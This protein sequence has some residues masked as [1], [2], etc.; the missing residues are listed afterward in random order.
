MQPNMG[1]GVV[2]RSLHIDEAAQSAM[3]R[4]FIAVTQEPANLMVLGDFNS[5]INSNSS[6]SSQHYTAAR[7]LNDVVAVP[8]LKGG[9]TVFDS[10]NQIQRKKNRL[11]F[12]HGP[13][14]VSFSLRLGTP[15]S[16][17]LSLRSGGK[18]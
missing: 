9:H 2:H 6:G 11:D 18:T 14:S 13:A 16:L 1:L 17:E 3:T 7:G 4:F 12:C 10:Y 5:H 8:T 15:L